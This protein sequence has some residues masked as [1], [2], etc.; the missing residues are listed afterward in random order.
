MPNAENINKLI[1]V[2]EADK[3]V[4]T[5][6]RMESFMAYISPIPEKEERGQYHHCKTA[7]CL[8][9]WANYLR[10]KEESPSMLDS[11]D[12]EDIIARTIPASGWLGLNYKHIHPLFFM[13]TDTGYNL[14]DGLNQSM[15]GWFDELP[16]DQR[17]ASA[18][19]VLE[20][21]RDENVVDWPRAL[22]E[23]GVKLPGS[24]D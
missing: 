3:E 24:E 7:L 2:L 8:A 12:F 4:G 6:F 18:I 21:L 15:I 14:I 20:I 19:R 22:R 10:L 13:R 1:A 11:R 23:S 16:T 9:G 17:Y 5:H